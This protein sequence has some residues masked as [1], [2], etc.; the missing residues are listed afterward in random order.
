MHIHK[1]KMNKL[2]VQ[3]A[4]KTS[5]FTKLSNKVK[6]FYEKLFTWKEQALETKRVK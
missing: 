1:K 5:L 3:N 6:M 2:N 4:L